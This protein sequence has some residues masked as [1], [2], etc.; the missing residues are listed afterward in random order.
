TTAGYA[1]WQSSL[2]VTSTVTAANLQIATTNL[3]G[4]TFGNES[5]A[6]TGNSPLVSTGS[7]TVQNSTPG[8]STRPANV[9]LTITGSGNLASLVTYKIWSAGSTG[10]AGCTPTATIPTT[11]VTNGTWSGTSTLTT[12][13]APQAFAYYCVRSS[14]ATRSSVQTAGGTLSFTATVAGAI[15]LYNFSGS[16]SATANQKTQYIYPTY[17]PATTTWNW[18]RP[19]F[20]NASYKYCLDVSGNATDPGTIVISYGCK[21]TTVSNQ[22]WKFTATTTSGFFTIT[23]RNAPALRIDNTSSSNSGVGVIVDTAGT[24]TSADQQWQ[25]QQVSSGVYEFVNSYSGMCM[26]SPDGSTENLGQIQQTPCN[27]SQFQQFLISPTLVGVT[28]NVVNKS[29]S[30]NDTFTWSS[31]SVGSGPYY[32]VVTHGGTSTELS[33]TVVAGTSFSISYPTVASY[34][35]GTYNV[36]IA[37]GNRTVI[38]QGTVTAGGSIGS[39][40]CSYADLTS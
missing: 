35:N 1:Y 36:T 31:T 24:S 21:T 28:C 26:T 20:S 32:V 17:S 37:D 2:T 19:N 11:G 7:I 18:I 23:P 8:P 12:T 39:S 40:S 30:A 14:I 27:G 22:Q 15:S 10:V 4:A 3:T 25:L 34:G 13:L 16:A 29:G 6:S 5:I 38:A 33:A 9:T